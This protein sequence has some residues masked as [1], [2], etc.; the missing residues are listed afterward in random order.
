MAANGLFQN[1]HQSP[2][3]RTHCPHPGSPSD[4]AVVAG[5]Q[6]LPTSPRRP[7]ENRLQPKVTHQTPAPTRSSS[8]LQCNF[9]NFLLPTLV[10]EW[11][12]DNH[13]VFGKIILYLQ[14]FYHH[15]HHTYSLSGLEM[16]R[17]IV[18]I[19]S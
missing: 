15:L 7:K 6:Q 14:M 12:S 1:G 8:M 4:T 18:F 13:D 17:Y 9:C 19:S 11:K 2:V 16:T 3:L 10:A 5:A